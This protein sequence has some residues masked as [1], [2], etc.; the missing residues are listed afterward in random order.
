MIASPRV[1]HAVQ[2]T[3]T[4]VVIYLKSRFSGH[5][6]DPVARKPMRSHER[7]EIMAKRPTLPPVDHDGLAE[8]LSALGYSVRLELLE[9]LRMPHALADIQLK[10]RR[11]RSPEAEGAPASRSTVYNHLEKLEEVGLVRARSKERGGRAIKMY[12]TDSQRLYALLEDLRRVV[13][14]HAGHEEAG[15]ATGTL[16]GEPRESQ[17][18]GPRLVLVHGLYE[19]RAYPL[20]T[21]TIVGDRWIIGRKTGLPVSL[22]YDPYASLENSYVTQHGSQFAIH[23]N[24]ESKNGTL[25]N[26]APLARGG[27]AKLRSGDVVGVGRS[28]LSFVPE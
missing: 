16:R 25:V 24:L 9:T 11:R 1:R 21:S 10:A 22:D 17:A 28:L 7:P 2:P 23:D 15:D 8:L 6:L 5:A 3:R 20:T 19:G 4:L 12:S 27:F 18:S 26:W 14:L 13:A